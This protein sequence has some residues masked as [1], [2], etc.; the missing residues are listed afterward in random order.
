MGNP[1]GHEKNL[2]VTPGPVWQRGVPGIR[3]PMEQALR[4]VAGGLPGLGD[5]P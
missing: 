1:T 5:A 2:R 4:A 3:P